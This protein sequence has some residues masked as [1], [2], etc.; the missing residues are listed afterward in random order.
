ML[1]PLFALAGRRGW[2]IGE[3]GDLPAFCGWVARAGHRRIQLLPIGEIPVGERSPYSAITAFAL[4]PIYVTLEEVEDFVA[5]GGERALGAA[6]RACLDAVRLAHGIDYDAVRAVKERALEVAF[7]HFVATEWVGRSARAAAFARFCR[8]EAAWLDDYALFRSLKAYHG[9]PAWPD[10]PETRPAGPVARAGGGIGWVFRLYVQWVAAEQWERARRAA[11][12]A[13]VA[14]DG[15]LPFMVSGD[16]ADV[17]ARQREFALDRSVGAPP[18]AF[19]ERGQDWRLPPC[20]WDV[21]AEGGFAWLCARVRRTA[22]LFDGCRIDHVVGY[23]RTWVRAADGPPGFVPEEEA[24]QRELGERLLRVMQE[25]APGLRLIAEDLGVIPEF[26]RSALARLGIPGYRVLRWE[27]DGLAF[28]DPTAFPALSVTTSGTHDTSTLAT[29]WSDELEDADRRALAAVPAFAALGHAG[30]RFT[31]AVHGALLAGIYG[32]GS[33]LVV[34]PLPDAYGGA[35]RI[36]VPATVGPAN[37]NYRLP[38]R[39]DE[40]ATGDA[41]AC[42]E[43]LAAL[44]RAS[45]R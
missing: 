9:A 42:A 25:A 26:V 12:A 29:W 35:E 18:D 31:P 4:D 20:R 13:G 6:A 19:D 36:N 8:A 44:A 40:L 38:W 32:S 43:R 39:S 3:F 17:W 7:G 16:S 11:R 41:A 34:L 23:F 37:W 15:D 30:A 2:G 5:T 14:L 22:A 24:Q 33:A 21:M 27:R 28:R 10:W 45:G 1:L